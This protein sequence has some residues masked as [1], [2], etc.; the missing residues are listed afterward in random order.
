MCVCKCA[1]VCVHA[2]RKSLTQWCITS[3]FE[4]CA[5]LILFV[6]FFNVLALKN[7]PKRLFRRALVNTLMQNGIFKFYLKQQEKD[8]EIM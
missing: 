5:T 2:H 3:L 4:E 8:L 7:I 6:Y 1:H